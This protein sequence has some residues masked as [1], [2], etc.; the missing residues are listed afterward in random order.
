MV[1]KIRLSLGTAIELGLE[2]GERDPNFST[3]F[4]MIYQEGKCEANCAF[5]PQARDSRAASDRLS[6]IS[7]PEYNL[8]VV[9]EHWPS[10]GKFRRICIQTICYNEV[11]QDVVAIVHRVRRISKLPISVA[12]HPISTDEMK[13]LELA[14][15]SNIG[16][17]IDACTPQLFDKIKGESRNSGYRWERH[18]KALKNALKIF[19]KGRVTTHLI[20][21]LGETE[22]DAVDFIFQMAKMGITVG[23]FAFTNI[24]GTSLENNTQPS[25]SSYRRIQA[26]RYLVEKGELDIDDVAYNE[27]GDVMVK[28]DSSR[29]RKILSSSTAFQVSGCKGCNRPFYNER[30]RGPMYNYPRPL[31]DDE[32][33][34]ALE[35]SGLIR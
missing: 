26:V 5:C 3:I 32:I 14:G 7:W 18:V 25:I 1:K 19:G 12:I 34:N 20:V 22:K 27:E 35:E 31:N 2:E 17:A 9:L 33:Q 10:P 24:K 29:V 8:E 13:R 15:V 21:G 11:V 6:R 16:I 28:M 4:L 23:L 30:P